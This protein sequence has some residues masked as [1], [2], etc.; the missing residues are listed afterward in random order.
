MSSFNRLHPDLDA[1]T[2][3]FQDDLLNEIRGSYLQKL[4]P[5]LENPQNQYLFE[6]GRS[7]RATLCASAP[8]FALSFESYP[9]LWISNNNQEIY[10]IF[11]RFFEASGL[12]EHARRLV[13]Y[14]ESIVMYC[15]FL[16]VGN[17]A[18]AAHWHCDYAPGANAFTLITPLFELEPEHGHLLYK[19][20]SQT[21]RYEYP[22][23]KAIFFGDR[24]AH[25]T[26]PYLPSDSKRVLVSMTFG[27]DKL[28]YWP[29]L[30]ETLESQAR[31]FMLPCGH[32]FG[33]CDCLRPSVLER[34]GRRLYQRLVP[35]SVITS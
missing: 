19:L 5:I 35:T 12:A 25:C 31:Y 32:I 30:K 33:R 15:G 34:L 11:R 21:E 6:G 24:T 3:R 8:Y 4:A 27:T 20:G 13:D 28:E 14:R 10:Q 29:L 1:Y 26:E 2:F 16:V 23:G 17:R 18:P 7:H 22:L 9:L